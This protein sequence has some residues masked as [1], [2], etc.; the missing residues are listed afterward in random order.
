MRYSGPWKYLLKHSSDVSPGHLSRSADAAELDSWPV[1][2]L[3]ICILSVLATTSKVK[4][5]NL[6]LLDM[7]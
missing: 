1:L 3:E 5:M 2:V 7:V 4:I 6:R